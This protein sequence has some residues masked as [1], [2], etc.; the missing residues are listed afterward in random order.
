MRLS[1]IASR[2]R[3]RVS[4]AALLYPALALVLAACA[5]PRSFHD[6][7]SSEAVPLDPWAIPKPSALDLAETTWRPAAGHNGAAALAPSLR[8]GGLDAAA[9]SE[10]E[11]LVGLGAAQIVERLGY[12][13]LIRREPPAQ[14]WQYQGRG[15][16][17]D[18][19]L[20]QESD[21]T[22]RVAFAQYRTPGVMQP[23]WDACVKSVADST[24]AFAR[25]P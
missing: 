1:S 24:P 6:G 11:S 12:P 10:P 22:A 25:T 4:A 19:F 18:V 20:Y 7:L 16:I 8:R 9:V 23:S 17:L 13:P 3:R 21:G 15:C 14:V 5:G 2:G